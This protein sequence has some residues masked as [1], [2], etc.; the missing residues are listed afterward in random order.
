MSSTIRKLF[1]APQ[2]HLAFFLLLRMGRDMEKQLRAAT[3]FGIGQ[4]VCKKVGRSISS[5]ASS[6]VLVLLSS[7]WYHF[8]LVVMRGLNKSPTLC[9]MM[10]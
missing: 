9:G 5:S 8:P 6:F 10:K 3:V 2:T 1:L 4:N 7:C